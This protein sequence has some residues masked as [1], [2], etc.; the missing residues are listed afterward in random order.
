VKPGTILVFGRSA[1]A[2]LLDVD[3]S[4]EV[5]ERA[6]ELQ[7]LGVAPLP[8]ALGIPADGGWFHVKAGLLGLE[9]PYFAAKVNANFPENTARRRL[10]TIQGVI[11]LMDGETGTPLALLDSGEVTA[12]RTAAATAVAARR[13]ARSDARSVMICGCGAQAAAQLTAL[14][15]VLPL[16]RG[17]AYDLDSASADRFAAASTRALRIPV[18]AVRDL[19]AT[20]LCDI[21]VT[22]T[23]S[24]SPFVGPED[25]VPGTFIAAVGADSPEKQ[26]LQPALLAQ[27]VVIVDL[28]EQ[29]AAIGELHHALDRGLLDRAQVRELGA[30]V[31]GRLPGRR[32][33]DETIVFDSTG[34]ALQDVAAAA[35]V[36]EAGLRSGGGVPVDLAA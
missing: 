28:L 4:I 18:E 22:C 16:E 6:F 5:V 32:T 19:A 10:P 34:I 20:R 24:R 29:C 23:P 9:R 25:V 30:I 26:E 1:V 8:I 13:L 27:S 15:R 12:R 35:W 21:I 7:G 11:V 36:Y 31:A 17:F 2:E 3:A 33:A 14:A